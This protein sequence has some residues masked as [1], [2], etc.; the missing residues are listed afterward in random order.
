MNAERPA[1]PPKPQEGKG[2]PVRVDDIFLAA[3]E[4]P[5]P[6]WSS[7]VTRV[8]GDDAALCHSVFSLLRAHDQIGP[9]DRLGAQMP[10]VWAEL[11]GQGTMTGETSSRANSP[12]RFRPGAMLGRYEIRERLG[13]GGMG[14]VYRAFDP[15]LQREVAVKVIARRIEGHPDVLGRFEAEARAASALNHPN[16]VTVYDIGEQEAFPYF[17]MELVEGESLRS[18]IDEPLPVERIV[19]LGSQL[20]GALAAAHER[21]VVHR[22]L[23]PENVVVTPQGVAKILDFGVAQFQPV[24]LEVH[25]LPTL[26]AGVVGTVGYMAPEALTGRPADHRADQFALGAIL[27]ELATGRPCFRRSS[28]AET[29]VATLREEPEPLGAQRPELP[30]PL[31]HLVERCLAKEPADRYPST[32]ALHK[33]L[34]TLS[35]GSTPRSRRQLTALPASPNPLIG[36]QGELH[37]IQNLILEARVRLLTV[38]GP[39]GCGK[40][41]LAIEAA[42]ALEPSFPGGILFVSLAALT[43]P[44]LVASTLARAVGGVEAGSGRELP[45]LFVELVAEGGPILLV[46]DNFEQI[47]DAAPVVGNLLAGCAELSVLV[48]SREVLRLQAEHD[49]P[50]RPLAV[51]SADPLMPEEELERFPAVALFVDRARAADPGFALTPENAATVAELC[52]RLDGLPLALELAAV[53]V[54]SLTPAVMLQRLESRLKLL[55]GGA[56]DL[57]DRQRT[58]RQAMDWSYELL[59]PAEQ[60]AFQRLA[61]FAGGFTLEAAEAVVDPFGRLERD[62]VGMV[63]S[64]LD[65]SLLARSSNTTG[66]PRFFLLETVREYALE[67]LAVS[68]DEALVRK[69][70]AAY[71]LVLAQEGEARR[72]AARGPRGWGASR[73]SATT[74]EPRWIGWSPRTTPNGGCRSPRGCSPSGSAARTSRRD[75]GGSTRSWPCPRL[76]PPRGPGPRPCGLPRASF[77]ISGI[78]RRPSSSI[79]SPSASTAGLATGGDKWRRSTPSGSTS[80][81]S[82]GR[83]KPGSV[84]RAVSS[85]GAS[86]A[87]VRATAARCRTTPPCSV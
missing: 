87:T 1:R 46:V 45:D 58:L 31:V 56:R 17:V 69:A 28:A 21:G 76:R 12:L 70:H 52:A 77:F 43:D 50:L 61:V 60:T 9:L 55:T 37:Q 42:R 74:S 67:R 33:A 6:E 24:G 19:R 47:V 35:V 57:P 59:E 11:A 39:G 34:S 26:S 54:R 13:V 36:R 23:K 14:E 27:Y 68:P 10:A 79:G 66:E 22:D 5:K 85:C 51:P 25:D 62:V 30:L 53:R 64:L 3:L 83:V 44:E 82:G 86:W 78:R 49:F 29:L 48:T 2:R 71:F 38:T 84:T 41:R 65:K 20:A 8:C 72:A 16:I 4:K 40:T 32:W 18:Q 7:F 73:W 80:P 15:R 63:G 81:T 75:G